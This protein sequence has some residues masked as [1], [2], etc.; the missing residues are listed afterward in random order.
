MSILVA[1][2][3]LLGLMLF[4]RCTATGMAMHVAAKDLEIH[5]LL[6]V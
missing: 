3:S 1:L 6:G 4:L 2:V 5:K